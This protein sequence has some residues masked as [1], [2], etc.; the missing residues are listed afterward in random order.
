MLRRA[1]DSL[2][3]FQ[4]V[5]KHFNVGNGATLK[6]VDGVSLTIGRGETFG[7]VG[8]SGCGKTTIGRLLVGLYKPSEGSITYEG[9]DITRFGGAESK[10]LTRQIQMIFQDPYSSLNPR[11]TIADTIAEGLDIHGLVRGGKRR[12]ERVDE[13]LETVGLG[14]E[15]ASRYPHEFSGGQRQRAGIARALAVDPE[16]IVADE[17]VSALDVSIQAQITNLMRRLQRERNLTYLFISHD[18]SVVRYSCEYI[19]V[20]YLGKIVE[21]ADSD[22]LYANPIHPYTQALLSA[23]PRPDPDSEVSRERIVLKGDVPDA[24]NVPSGCRFNQRCPWATEQCA[25][26]EPEWRQPRRGHWVSA[27]RCVE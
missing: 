25:K 12:E 16:L 11:M 2:L 3:E 4:G 27:C 10:R 24:V 5:K 20:M 19:A 7:L 18:L 6:A 8:E 17:P 14:S 21:M 23:I 9:K 22:E 15:S 1:E 13:L 26:E